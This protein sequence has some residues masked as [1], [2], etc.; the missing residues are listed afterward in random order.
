MWAAARKV[1]EY[2]N[3]E[4][5]ALI[6]DYV[7][8]DKKR[9]VLKWRLVNEWT[10]QQIAEE[11]EKKYKKYISVRNVGYILQKELPKLAKHMK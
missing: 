9:D 11:I 1:R 8:G 5:T 2:T 6:D 4:I 10:Y 7:H 3:S